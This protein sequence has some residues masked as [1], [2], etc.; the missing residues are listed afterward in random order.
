MKTTEEEKTPGPNGGLFNYDTED[1]D[2]KQKLLDRFD[3]IRKRKIKM[4][5]PDGKPIAIIYNGYVSGSS[6]SG[7]IE[8]ILY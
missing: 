5:L 2:S 6:K 1:L 8:A 4:T 3:L 7:E